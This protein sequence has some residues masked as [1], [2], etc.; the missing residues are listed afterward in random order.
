MHKISIK[1]IARTSNLSLNMMTNYS[2][3]IFGILLLVAVLLAG[4]EAAKFRD[5]ADDE[6]YGILKQ[7]GSDVLGAEQDY[8]IRTVWSGRALA[9][10][11]SLGS[12]SFTLPTS[13]VRNSRHANQPHA[14]P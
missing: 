4:C 14:T 9:L 7:R 8:D 3:K 12:S 2:F 11:S 5:A 13:F 6:V 10:V 1:T